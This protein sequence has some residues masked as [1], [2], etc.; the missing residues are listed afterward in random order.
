MKKPSF[1]RWVVN[2]ALIGLLVT[3]FAASGL[4][5]GRFVTGF[6]D[7][8]LMPGMTE[9]PDT[10]VSFDTTAGRI[11]IAF[12]RTPADRE[13]IKTFYQTTLAQLGWRKHSEARFLREEEVLN[14]DYLSD[15]PDTIVRFSL[16]PQ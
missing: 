7:L 6:D 8:P 13:K 15:G 2:A 4:A 14:F 16:L 10:D 3:G 1:S 5:A 9:I 12:V 11:V